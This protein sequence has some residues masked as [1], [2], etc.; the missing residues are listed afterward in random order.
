MR[1][2]GDELTLGVE[3][4]LESLEQPVERVP[5][6]PQL[7]VGAGQREPTVQV[8][9]GDVARRVRDRAQR[10]QHTAR[11]EPAEP[12]R[13]HGHDRERDRRLDQ[14]L[15]QRGVGL[16]V[17]LRHDLLGLGHR[18]RVRHAVDRGDTSDDAGLAGSDEEVAAVAVCDEE[19]GDRQQHRAAGE[20]EAAVE[21]R[22][23]EPDTHA[24]IR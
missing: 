6:L 2:I 18:C 24:S 5:E 23:A 19:V 10:P 9:R 8:A 3:G 11:H 1:C 4:R 21:G 20:E 16:C 12:D 14:E 22:Q 15:M 13:D 7:V 17:G